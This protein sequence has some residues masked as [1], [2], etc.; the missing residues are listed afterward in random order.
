MA[1]A[2]HLVNNL[3]ICKILHVG[4]LKNFEGYYPVSYGDVGYITSEEQIFQN[5]LNPLFQK[6]F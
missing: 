6:I 1:V 5:R 4:L 2:Q 3:S